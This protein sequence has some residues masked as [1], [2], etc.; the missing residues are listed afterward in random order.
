MRGF[1]W[2]LPT[3]MCAVF[4]LPLGIAR[5]ADQLS[6]FDRFDPAN[7]SIEERFSWQP[8]ELV[9]VIGTHH[10]RAWGVIR[11]IGYT[12][13][14][15]WIVGAGSSGP[16]F[17]WDS[18]TLRTVGMLQ[19]HRGGVEELQF[20]RDGRWLATSSDFG[21][22]RLW[23][24]S[25]F[26]PREGA[27]LQAFPSEFHS[28]IA[29]NADGKRLAT[30]GRTPEEVILWRHEDGQLSEETV[31]GMLPASVDSLAFSPNGTLLA[32]GAV[33]H[34]AE[35][36]DVRL[37]DVSKKPPM[38]TATVADHQFFVD[39][40]AFSPDGRWLA[41]GGGCVVQLSEVGP[42]DPAP[43][44]IGHF[45]QGALRGPVSSL[46]FSPDGK[47]LAGAGGWNQMRLWDI[48]SPDPLTLIAWRWRD[49]Q[50]SANTLVFSPDGKT[51]AS[52][53]WSG[54]VRLWEPDKFVP[55]PRDIPGLPEPRTGR[56]MSLDVS[57]DDKLLA[58]GFGTTACIVDLT[59]PSGLKQ[60]MLPEADSS[61]HVHF[62]D[63]N[64]TIYAFD[65]SGGLC[66]WE[67]KSR[68]K[69][70][71]VADDSEHGSPS[72]PIAFLPKRDAILAGFY[73]AA[74]WKL[75]GDKA[76]P[77]SQL[78]LEEPPVFYEFMC[79]AGAPDEHWIAAGTRNGAVALIDLRGDQPI[80]SEDFCDA[81]DDE[82]NSVAFSPDGR[83][84][85]SAGDDSVV[86]L[87]RLDAD[88]PFLMRT[89][90][91]H[92]GSVLKAKFSPGGDIIA[93]CSVDNTVRLW[94]VH[95]GETVKEWEFPGFVS[96]FAF[97]ADGRYLVTANSNG[98]VY[99]LKVPRNHSKEV[100][101]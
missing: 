31:I 28:A 39:E 9:A 73:G 97:S 8:S 20:S 11:R 91:G 74:F 34:E 95:T 79:C 4:G 70:W 80:W 56:A 98:T 50:S 99:V 44:F 1:H 94:N 32:V 84:L 19:G 17:I 61:N 15:K 22:V 67:V 81:H 5:A 2:L 85:A 71:T 62:G 72:G 83:F 24:F 25:S 82:V 37:F 16:I 29:I 42:R 46:A 101:Q 59:D 49:C 68:K 48:T 57:S 87:W 7:I 86:N 55:T 6:V 90:E 36:K 40:L 96:D 30:M 54:E 51:L 76:V 89:F 60:V 88:E 26:P 27:I 18:R 47:T 12:L 33:V 75:T 58:I 69:T 3:L 21:E 64:R 92:R 45:V 78:R 63:Q 52:A 65:H 14:G 10:G 43:R 93:T 35:T 23:D 13:D 100:T 38:L 66:A 41:T 53:G 77:H